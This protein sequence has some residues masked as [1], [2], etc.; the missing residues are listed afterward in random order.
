MGDGSV[1]QCRTCLR[2]FPERGLVNDG[3]SELQDTND[4]VVASRRLQAS[5][6]MQSLL[7]FGTSFPPRT[8]S[9]SSKI[10]MIS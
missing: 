10:P 1:S 7:P 9:E 6:L 3:I 2:F 8:A 4:L 5:A